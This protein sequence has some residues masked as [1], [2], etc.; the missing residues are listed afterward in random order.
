MCVLIPR[1]IGTMIPQERF[2]MSLQPGAYSIHRVLHSG[3]A[4]VGQSLANDF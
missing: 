4:G 2:C 3:G 1:I